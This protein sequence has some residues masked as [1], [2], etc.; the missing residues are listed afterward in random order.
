MI[1]VQQIIPEIIGS[2]KSFVS[3]IAPVVDR[4]GA[5]ATLTDSSCFFLLQCY[6]AG[7]TGSDYRFR[8]QVQITGSDQESIL[9]RIF[10][11]PHTVEGISLNFEIMFLLVGENA[12]GKDSVA[13]I[14]ENLY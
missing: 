4:P 3:G 7:F 8:S 12:R 11:S 14:D 5:P 13:V 6:Q 1:N 10:Q 2:A 9:D